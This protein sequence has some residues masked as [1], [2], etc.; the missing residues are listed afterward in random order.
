MLNLWQTSVLIEDV[1]DT[2]LLDYT[3]NYLLM[4]KDT[5]VGKESADD[6][7]LEK[8]EMQRVKNDIFKPAFNSYLN[9]TLNKNIDDW[10]GHKMNG[11]LVSYAQGQALN[12]HNHRGSQLSSVLYLIADDSESGGE[13]V[14]TDPRQNANRGY[15]LSFQ[16][17]FAPLKH[18]PVCGQIVVFPSFLYHYVT[19]YQS[20]IRL[21][22]PT[23]LFLFNSR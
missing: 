21:A 19:T 18:K 12:Y 6:S 1:T 10:H 9:Q 22:V 2:E 7:L 20:N 17:W 13:I 15:D 16:E 3:I 8:P 5:L 14:F 4:N 11:W 23:D